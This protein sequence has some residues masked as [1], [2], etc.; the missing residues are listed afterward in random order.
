MHGHIQEKMN[1]VVVF[2]FT[3]ELVQ[4]YNIEIKPHIKAKLEMKWGAQNLGTLLPHFKTFLPDAKYGLTT[5]FPT[6]VHMRGLCEGRPKKACT[7]S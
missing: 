1:R 3:S 2:V 7:A 6:A 4:E 5:N